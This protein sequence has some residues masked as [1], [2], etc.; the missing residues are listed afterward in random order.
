MPDPRQRFFDERAQRWEANCYPEAVRAR[1]WPM[2]AGFGLARGSTVLD[3]G[4]G[5][6]V[7]WPYLRR[8]LGPQGR[9]AAFD[10]SWEMVRTASRRQ[11]ECEAAVVQATAMALPFADASFDALVCFACFPHFADQ[12]QAM[13][14]MARVAKAGASVFIAH[15]LGRKELA[16]HHAGAHSA[17]SQDELPEASPMRSLF[18][19]AGFTEPTI[20]DMPDRYLATGRRSSS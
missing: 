13:Q 6:G 1:I 10:L 12:A 7:L 19:A 18:V 20:I 15:L 8:T 5:P 9:I 3:M 2:V 17:V 11:R 14:E 16:A 4:T